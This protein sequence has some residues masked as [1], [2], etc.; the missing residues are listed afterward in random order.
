MISIVFQI[1]LVGAHRTLSQRLAEFDLHGK[2]AASLLERV[3]D[4]GRMV[5]QTSFVNTN[6]ETAPAQKS[7][8]AAGQAEHS[9]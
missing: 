4:S 1:T 5:K 8:R 9:C 2:D 3:E 6:S 7:R